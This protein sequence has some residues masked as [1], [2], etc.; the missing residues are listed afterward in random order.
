MGELL[1]ITRPLDY[2][3][4]SYQPVK[5]KVVSDVIDFKSSRAYKNQ[6]PENFDEYLK[7]ISLNIL[8]N[9]THEI[10][11]KKKYN[12]PKPVKR[13]EEYVPEI[14]TNMLKTKEIDF[15][16]LKEI[17]D[18][19]NKSEDKVLSYVFLRV[20]NTGMNF[21]SYSEF[22]TGLRDGNEI[23]TNS[24]NISDKAVRLAVKSLKDK[25]II[26]THNFGDYK[27]LI[28]ILNT[29]KGNEIYEKI[30]SGKFKRSDCRELI[31][32]IERDYKGFFELNLEDD[33]L[34]V[35]REKIT[36]GFGNFYTTDRKNFP[37]AKVQDIGYNSILKNE[38]KDKST[39]YDHMN[40]LL[41]VIDNQE[42][43]S[44]KFK[45]LS[46]KTELWSM[47]IPVF[48]S[49]ISKYGIG[50]VYSCVEYLEKRERRGCK[51][52]NFGAYLTKTL[53]N[54][55]SNKNMKPD[56]RDILKVKDISKEKYFEVF[57]LF[58]PDI[59]I[60]SI[61][62]NRFFYI[63]RFI[64]SLNTCINED[65]PC[66]KE[67]IKELKSLIDIDELK[68]ILLEV[69]SEENTEVIINKILKET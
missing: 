61:F 7:E 35:S 67:K 52:D 16:K 42:I 5:L 19:L 51:I 45:I 13:F 47:P 10:S 68:K 12:K 3:E 41:T 46:E 44:E 60:D 25:N 38:I 15:L 55:N 63:N 9:S 23:I 49:L 50:K 8:K 69:E 21:I 40:Q 48:K 39:H 34:P 36:G 26:F 57:K 22:Q 6:N 65:D 31:K 33:I 2:R 1:R 53:R 20:L 58:L 37:D 43:S 64:N 62:N 56:K 28:Y 4:K 66:Y 29:S 24:V 27:E 30:K 32:K 17:T 59:S 14:F 11:I 18:Y 54:F